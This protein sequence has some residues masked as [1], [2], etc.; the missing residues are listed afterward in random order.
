M[1]FDG[2]DYSLISIDDHATISREVLFLTHDYSAYKALSLIGEE[3]K[4]KRVDLPI[5]V[6]KNCFIGARATLLPGTTIGDN[7]VIGACSVV[8]GTIPDNSVV[9]GNPAK[10]LKGTEEYARKYL[11]K[12]SQM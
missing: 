9:A 6:G 8:K 1:H 4:F 2:V 5:K 3:K 11:Q 7:C 10:I 12:Y